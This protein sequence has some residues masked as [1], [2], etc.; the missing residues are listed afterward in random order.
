MH[1]VSFLARNCLIG[2]I[3]LNSIFANFEQVWRKRMVLEATSLDRSRGQR[4]GSSKVT[5][6]PEV[7]ALREARCFVLAVLS[8]FSLFYNL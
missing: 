4:V 5:V 2:F 8:H 7:F 3:V 6:L 1:V